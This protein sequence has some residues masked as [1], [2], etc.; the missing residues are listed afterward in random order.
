MAHFLKKT[1][2]EFSSRNIFQ[3]LCALLLVKMEICKSAIDPVKHF[4]MGQPRPLFKQTIQFFTTNQ[5]ENM[6]NVHTVYGAEIQTHD[7]SN[8]SRLTKPLDQGSRP[9]TQFVSVTHSVLQCW[10]P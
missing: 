6:P 8:M 4:L 2:N 7:I 1:I 5:C 3:K 10:C 9:V